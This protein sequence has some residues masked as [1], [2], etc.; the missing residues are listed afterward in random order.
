MPEHPFTETKYIPIIEIKIREDNTRRSDLDLK[1]LRESIMA[2][3]IIQPL[4]VRP[5]K[6]RKSLDGVYEL[7]A[8]HRRFEAAVKIGLKLVPVII[9]EVDDQG[10]MLITVTENLQRK[11]LTA[12]EEAG[13]LKRL[14]DA[15]KKDLKA[16]AGDLGR[17]PQWVARRAKLIDLIPAWIKAL[18]DPAGDFKNWS[19]GHYELIARFDSETQ[20]SILDHFDKGD[21]VWPEEMTV[22]G[23]A[24]DLANLMHLLKKAPW[25]IKDESILPE[26]GACE[27]CP[28]RSCHQA[29]LFDDDQTVEKITANDK[30]LD[31]DCWDKKLLIFVDRKEVEL[32]KKYQNL[33][34][35]DNDNNSAQGDDIYTCGS[36][37]NVKKKDK[38]AIPA[39]VVSGPGSG[40]LRWVKLESWAEKKKPSRTRGEDGKPK[41]ATKDERYKKLANRRNAYIID[42]IR[43]T[44]REK[45]LPVLILKMKDPMRAIIAL[46]AAFGT[47]RKMDS[48]YINGVGGAE[49]WDRFERR[50]KGEDTISILWDAM[51]AVFYSRLAYTD[52]AS[53]T[54]K[55]PEAKRICNLIDLNFR[56]LE[57][58]AENEIAVPKSWAKLDGTDKSKPAPKRKAKVS[59]KPVAKKTKKKKVKRASLLSKRG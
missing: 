52:G 34:K 38:G 12:L 20:K 53:A 14:L 40:T 44:L 30:C 15:G 5:I 37:E 6:N 45:T 47:E 31:R 26:R 25:D 55:I 57:K 32:R 50:Y 24:L 22:D 29:L 51:V 19:A 11:D 49:D 3:G 4:I 23:L 9:H 48:I 41:P 33:I 39:I 43:E 8:G 21:Y 7:L 59:K 36:Y 35:D 42:A 2:V 28:S 17:S 56:D 1:Q 13:E 16:I 27:A 54:V 58:K 46:A 18:Q 10:A